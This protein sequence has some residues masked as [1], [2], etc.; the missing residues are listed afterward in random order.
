[1]KKLTKS[2]IQ[3]HLR[4][5]C[6]LGCA[7]FA[8][9][10]SSSIFA[11]FQ[12]ISEESLKTTREM[13]I[14]LLVS[15]KYLKKE[16]YKDVSLDDELSKKTLD[17]YLDFLDPNRVY[18]YAS[19][20]AEFRLEQ[21]NIDNQFSQGNPELGFK[22][23]KVLR[24]RV[25]ERE[26]YANQ[27][28]KNE[29]NFKL[30]ETF[31]VD[32]SESLWPETQADMNDLWRKRVKNSV[33]IQKLDKTPE[34]EIRTSLNKRYARQANIIWQTRPE[35]VFELY[36]NA[37]M[38]EVGPHTQYM[39]RVT[40][41][42]FKINLSLSL[43]GI[44]ASLQSENDYTIIRKIIA[45]GPASKSGKLN[46]D[47]KIVGVGQSAE[48]IEDVTGWRLMDVVSKIRG[49]KGSK[50]FLQLLTADSPPGST[51]ETVELI[52][53]VISL[54]D[55]AAQLD[56][57]EVN[58]KRFA[59]IDIPSFYAKQKRNKTGKNTVVSTSKDVER[60]IN[61]AKAS[62][63]IDGLIIDL[64]GN[65]GGYLREAI[66]LTG[67]FIDK[68]PV[69][70]VKVS[71]ENPVQ[72]NDR[73]SGTA[74]DGPLLVLVDK[75]SASASEIFAGA[76]KD[77]GRGIIVGERTFGKGTVQTTQPL[78]RTKPNEV[79]STLKL[80]IQQ[81]FRV[82]GESTQVKGVEPDVVLDTGNRGDFGEGMLDNA[83]PWA[84]IS[85]ALDSQNTITTNLN[86]LNQ[87]HLDR[88]QKSAA[89]TF[90]KQT[91]L[92]R[93]VNNDLKI[94]S[95]AQDKR[96]AF[97]ND[98]EK[99][100][101]D[102]INNYRE[103]LDLPLIDSSTLSDANKDLPNGDKHWTRVFQKEAALILYDYLNLSLIHI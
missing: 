102:Q 81:F 20:I 89:F 70:Q 64:R 34:D 35:E 41:E 69:V 68:G 5:T 1:M 10:F 78:K 44:G 103:S 56:Y 80:T 31:Q 46:I 16:H 58:D 98:Q 11:D 77:Y 87:L 48:N 50:V 47:D 57:Q 27:L 59:V 92:Q 82:N 40:A 15:L 79:S 19:D 49:K 90:L 62:G 94:V 61:E 36:L 85:S 42:N 101:V 72:L 7:L 95:L 6:L 22:I 24:K 55:S 17:R 93:K 74:Y 83:L 65:G 60:L 73:D 4:H 26:A 13:Q 43:E 84:K 53:D 18:F 51:P 39:S 71:N 45:G 3:S 67:L 76:I 54:E 23:Y 37:L 33:I 21:F 86:E 32:R 30:D 99:Q 29:F 8:T 100:S 12:P 63:K 14:D 97:A 2:K 9:T 96:T 66:N 75:S 25:R 88:A 38:R 28:L 52:R 91:A